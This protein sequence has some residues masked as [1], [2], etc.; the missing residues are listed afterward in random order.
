M[1]KVKDLIR[2]T[3]KTGGEPNKLGG[4]GRFKQ[5][6]N[7]GKSAALAAWIGRKDLG[8]TKFQKLA[9]KGVKGK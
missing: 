3:G 6:E 9:A 7:Q 8:K 5:L 4:G 1:S 2:K